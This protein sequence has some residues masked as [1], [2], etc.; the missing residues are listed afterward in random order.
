VRKELKDM[1]K[2]KSLGLIF[3]AT[4]L[5]LGF[6]ACE[7]DEPINQGNSIIPPTA[8][9]RSIAE[10][11]IADSRTDSMAVAL[12]V[13]NLNPIFEGPGAFT[14][15]APNN[16]AFVDVLASDSTWNRISDINVTAL[17]NLLYYHVLS[18]KVM[19][20]DLTDDTYGVTLNTQGTASKERTVLEVDITRGA[21]LNNSA[22]I[23]VANL[24]ATNGVIH[25]INEVLMPQNIV[26]I[27][28]DDE[29]FTSLVTAL[30][31]FG[32]TLTGALSGAG[33]FTVF[34]P[35]NAAFQRL[36]DSDTTWNS[37]RD[38][39]RSTLKSV[40]EYHVISGANARAV[41]L[42]QNQ[43]LTTLNNLTLQVDLSSG[44][45]LQTRSMAQRNVNIIVT[46][47]QGTNGVI[48]AVDEVLLP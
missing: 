23:T 27:A 40:L 1:K 2:L 16:Q 47:V 37:V 34:A 29:R 28:L 14:V 13:A 20:T 19:S 8:P 45:Q 26:Q 22:N 6:Y 24:E 18:S 30:S 32:D 25:V 7:D 33:P 36:L 41:T 12:D 10:I 4:S 5:M 39:P 3:L 17:T 43:N 15:F 48:H 9:S 44:A 42:R 38:I 35:T 11:A 46:D 31:V 21:T